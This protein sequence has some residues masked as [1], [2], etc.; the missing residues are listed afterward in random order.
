MYN[1]GS[2]LDAFMYA[3]DAKTFSNNLNNMPPKYQNLAWF[4]VNTVKEIQD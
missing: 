2:F 4:I 3:F 1:Y